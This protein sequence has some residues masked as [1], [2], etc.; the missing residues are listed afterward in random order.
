MIFH[1]P[2]ALLTPKFTSVCVGNSALGGVDPHLTFDP[3]IHNVTKKQDN[4]VSKA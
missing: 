2:R 1:K 4:F 3:Y